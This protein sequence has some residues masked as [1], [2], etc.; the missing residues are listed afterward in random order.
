[1][2]L[3]RFLVTFMIIAFFAPLTKPLALSGKAAAGG[4][5]CSLTGTDCKHHT[6]CSLRDDSG[7]GPA[8]GMAVLH[9]S[10][11]HGRGHRC[12]TF[13]ECRTKD[14]ASGIAVAGAH[15]PALMTSIDFHSVQTI[16]RFVPVD[17]VLFKDTVPQPPER[18]PTFS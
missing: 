6:L 16:N 15:M 4:A 9:N 5:M 2:A 14:D 10:S 1:M 3:R 12:D 11:G 17:G 7:H 13:F 8:H 18:P